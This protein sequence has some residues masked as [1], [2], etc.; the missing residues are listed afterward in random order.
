MKIFRRL[1]GEVHEG[2]WLGQ[3]DGLALDFALAEKAG[4]VFGGE[5]DV[6]PFGEEVNCPE[7]DVVAGVFVFGAG[8][9]KADD[10]QVDGL[11][12]L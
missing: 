7:A 10:D 3:D 11:A 1:A 9:T 8:I 6:V 2:T 4:V 12:A 5:A